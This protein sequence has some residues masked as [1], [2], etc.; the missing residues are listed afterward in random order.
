MTV[1]A[2]DVPSLSIFTIEADRKPVFAIAAKKHQEVELFCT[3]ERVRDK[4]KSL[5]S[6]GVRLC[7]D[8][9]ILRVR[10]ARSDERARYHEASGRSALDFP[11]VFLIDLD[12]E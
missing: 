12:E 6:G 7:D 2:T 9:S 3:D 11:V 10:L 1:P 4:L 8:Y 5:R